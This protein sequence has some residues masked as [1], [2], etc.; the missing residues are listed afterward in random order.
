MRKG[1]PFVALLVLVSLVMSA[2]ALAPV[3]TPVVAEPTPVAEPT[4]AAELTIAA[5][6]APAAELIAAAEPAAGT[7]FEAPVDAAKSACRISAARPCGRRRMRIR[8]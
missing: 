2:Q 7:F 3:P 6:P 1:L 8:C 4:V 5:E